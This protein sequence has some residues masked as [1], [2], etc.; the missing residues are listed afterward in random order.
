MLALYNK[1]DGVHFFIAGALEA[2]LGTKFPL[3]ASDVSNHFTC[4][5]WQSSLLYFFH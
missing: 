1:N 4:V 3:D 2:L 5:F